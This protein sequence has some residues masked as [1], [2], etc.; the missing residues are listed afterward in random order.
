MLRDIFMLFDSLILF[1]F[2][3]LFE[4]LMFFDILKFFVLLM[5]FEFL[6]HFDFLTLF[7]FLMLFDFFK[8]F[9]YLAILDFLTFLDLFAAS[10]SNWKRVWLDFA[11]L[12]S[13]RQWFAS[14]FCSLFSALSRTNTR[15]C[16]QLSAGYSSKGTRKI[17][18]LIYVLQKLGQHKLRSL[19]RS[20][21][22]L[23][24]DF[25]L[26]LNLWKKI[27]FSCMATLTR[28]IQLTLFV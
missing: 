26:P 22:P 24:R 18:K 15:H 20:R 19:A 25:T 28:P 1:N 17:S 13:Y 6:Q 12:Y 5:L 7:C 2:L 14:P 27:F 11:S 8:F 3:A 4:F 9:E 23:Y 10:S 21:S 16:T